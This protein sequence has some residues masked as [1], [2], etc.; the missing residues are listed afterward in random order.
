MPK[1]LFTVALF[2]LLGLAAFGQA[3]SGGSGETNNAARLWTAGASLGTCFSA[4]W[5][6]ITL[7]GTLSPVD[8]FFVELGLDLGF[9]GRQEGADY[10]SLYPFVHYAYFR[11]FNEKWGWYAGG[12]NGFMVS[13]YRYPEGRVSKNIF[14][15]DLIAGVNIL[16]MLDVSYTLRTNFNAASN[17][18]SVGY[19]YRFGK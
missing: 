19:V 18:I 12:G 10:F 14:A 5:L 7:H 8:N 6:V 4:P 2:L 1:R 15:I 3:R 17:K 16:N 11:P 13:R 9:A